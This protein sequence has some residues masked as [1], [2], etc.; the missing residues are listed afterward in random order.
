LNLGQ[1]SAARCKSQFKN[2]ELRRAVIVVLVA[3]N[4]Q[5][6]AAVFA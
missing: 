4:L 3:R 2:R 6:A 1:I 5:R